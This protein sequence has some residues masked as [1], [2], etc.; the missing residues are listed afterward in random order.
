M[1]T[2]LYENSKNLS[3]SQK[4]RIALAR[5]VLSNVDLVILDEATS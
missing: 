1:K 3:G 5:V 2:K 4:Q